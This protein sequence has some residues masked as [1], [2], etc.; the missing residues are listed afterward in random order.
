ML[1]SGVMSVCE[2]AESL[3]LSV[4]HG[5]RAQESLHPAFGGGS[6]SSHIGE[7]FVHPTA[8]QL[9]SKGENRHSCHAHLPIEYSMHSLYG[10]NGRGGP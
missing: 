7:L 4:F 1:P 6:F 2:V 9:Q 5:Q 10:S 8:S 3:I